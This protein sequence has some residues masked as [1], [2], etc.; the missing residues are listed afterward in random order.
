MSVG[1]LDS[2]TPMIYKFPSSI[3]GVGLTL[4]LA[5]GHE[6]SLKSLAG[7]SL[8]CDASHGGF[9]L[10]LKMHMTC[11]QEEVIQLQRATEAKDCVSLCSSIQTL[12]NSFGYTN[13]TVIRLLISEA[14]V[15]IPVFTEMKLSI[16]HSCQ[17][18]NILQQILSFEPRQQ[19]QH[20]NFFL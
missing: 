1:Q 3:G 20:F 13:S 8:L 19:L 10:C 5:P 12:L 18:C 2:Q 15:H 4:N 6:N 9:G 11:G 14:E 16:C 17:K 7:L